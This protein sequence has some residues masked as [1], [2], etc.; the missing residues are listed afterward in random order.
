MGFSTYVI[1]ESN[2]QNGDGWCIGSCMACTGNPI[3]DRDDTQRGAE[4]EDAEND[5]CVLSS[6][7][8]RRQSWTEALGANFVRRIQHLVTCAAQVWMMYQ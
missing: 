1:L 4:G 5:V 7:V 2:S 3:R 8:I 6:I